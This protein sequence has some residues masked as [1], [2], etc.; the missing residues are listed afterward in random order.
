MD[1]FLLIVV[2]LFIV[3]AVDIIVGVSNDAVNFLNSAIGSNVASFKTIMAVATVGI[4]VGAFTSS[5]LM[6]V[7]RKGVFD[8]GMFTYEGMMY[9]FLAV[10]LTDVILLD[11]FNTYAMPTSTTVSIVFELFGASTAM[12]LML[13]ATNQGGSDVVYDFIK[14]D[15]ALFIMGGIFLSILVAFTFGL[16]VQFFSRWWLSFSHQENRTLARHLFAGM[17]ITCITYFLLIKGLKGSPL[18]GSAFYV[19]ISEH[20]SLVIVLLLAFWTLLNMLIEKLSGFNP[21][22][23]VVLAG[24][25]ALAMAFAGND[26][27]NFI[28]V[29][30]GAYQGWQLE[31]GFSEV[32]STILMTSLNQSIKVPWLLLG[33]SGVLMSLTLWFSSKAKKVTET[34]INLA[35]Q[36]EATERFK[37]NFL[38]KGIVAIGGGVGNVLQAITPQ[39]IKNSIQQSYI[40]KT[41][42][43]DI[44]VED[45][46][47]FDLIRASVNLMMASIIISYATFKKLPLSTTFVSFMVAMGSSLA[48]GAWGRASA[49]AR[50][51]GVLNVIG[52]WL[53][54]AVIA[55]TS[56]ALM[57]VILFKLK[58]VGI[59]IVCAIAIFS[60]LRTNTT[61]FKRSK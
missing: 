39:P 15:Q 5:G 26:L 55:F 14:I 24:T 19:Y 27:V 32:S 38:A 50:V 9:V 1:I 46:P 20:I 4:L 30:I 41:V 31:G 36:G 29:P 8:P 17:A 13:I 34:E 53:L 43:P 3:A 18:K 16:L 49:G 23:T 58:L 42:S 6:E 10:M 51:A 28:G 45:K 44:A 2:I 48:D 21:L 40:A 61:V 56:A 52:G 37:P 11:L 12:A 59:V 25:F 33:L 35:R 54:T 7:A 47:A 57:A 22:K 60:V